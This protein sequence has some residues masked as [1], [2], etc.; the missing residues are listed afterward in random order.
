MLFYATA[1]DP[2]QVA[3]WLEVLLGVARDDADGSAQALTARM[4]RWQL[5]RALRLHLLALP[6]D[7]KAAPTQGPAVELA[8]APL[9][10]FPARSDAEGAEVVEDASA[11]HSGTPPRALAMR[12]FVGA[13]LT[14]PQL[15][16]RIPIRSLTALAAE[17]PLLDVAAHICALGTYHDVTTHDSALPENPIHSPYLLAHVLALTAKR[18]PHL[19]T[20]AEVCAYLEMLTTLQNALDKGTFVPPAS[21]HEP[22]AGAAPRTA[23]MRALDEVVAEEDALPGSAAAH[24][25]LDASVYRQLHTLVSPEHLHALLSASA[26]FSASTRPALCSFLL[27]TLIAWPGA[28]REA[29]LTT[30][31]YGYTSPARAAASASAPTVGAMVR[32]LW[33]GWVRNSALARRISAAHAP[34][35][36]QVIETLRALGAPGLAHEWGMFVVLCELYGRCLLTLGDDEF[37]PSSTGGVTRNPLTTD[38]VVSFSA[39]LRNLAFTMYWHEAGA[40]GAGSAAAPRVPETRMTLLELRELATR[41]LQ[42][43]YARDSRRPFAPEGHWHMLSQDDLSAFIQT[44]V[45]EDRELAPAAHD[46]EVQQAEA[47]MDVDDGAA[48]TRTKPPAALSARTMAFLGP[49]LGV[50]NNIPFVIPFEVRVEIF[51]Q[52]VRNDAERLGISRSIFSR[53]QRHRVTVRRGHIAEDGMAQLNGLGPHL[54]EPIEIVFVDQFGQEEAGIDGGGVFKEFLTS[55]V[56][57]V[58]DTD[59]GLWRANQRQELYPNPHSYAKAPEQ[60]VWYT[61]LGRILGK[62]LYEGILV[63]VKFAS[64]FLSKWLGHQSYLDDL[65]SLDSLDGEL[66][67]GLIYLKNYQ[68]DVEADLALSFTVADEE[69]GVSHTTELIPG[70]AEVPVTR[71]NRL[72][73][74]YLVSRYRLSKQIEPQCAAFFRGLSEMIHPRWLRLLNR[75]E[76]RVLVSGTEAPI[77][78]ADLRANTVYGGYHEKD[79]AVDYFW[80]ALEQL[81][82]PSRKAFLRFVTSSPNPPLL[83][84]AELNPKFA[85]RHAGDDAHRLPTA[86]TCVN[87]LKLPAYTSTE[88][89]LERLRYAIH[90]GAG[91]DLS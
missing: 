73:Y 54:K 50:L 40:S 16:S 80:Q 90:S 82:Q 1:L 63:D 15:L 72:S 68:G 47:E 32:E 85:I 88:Q 37:Y 12:T 7:R 65:A 49:R 8:L 39:L 17:F 9:A 69:F 77:D 26:R 53:T 71:E 79:L 41:V 61:F 42:Q 75:E 84:F 91:F 23:A 36:H 20:G 22:S 83:G 57:E 21:A 56:R 55:L 3:P 6:A 11:A 10:V 51:R 74:I 14:T 70:G 4:L 62:A 46:E 78:I 87:L 76:L 2:V 67:R 18:V 35:G 24:P 38:E 33:R 44:V 52:F 64:F 5:H 45:I 43:L 86:S 29:V 66:Y 31:L 59:R 81:D 48:P 13:F 19:R 58:F 89:C 60:L 25:A 34:T 28:E 27:A 30:V